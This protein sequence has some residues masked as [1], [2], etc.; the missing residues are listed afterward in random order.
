MQRANM[1]QQGETEQQILKRCLKVRKFL[2]HNKNKIR[3]FYDFFLF[4]EN[5]IE[6]VDNTRNT[7]DSNNE[8]EKRENIFLNMYYNNKHVNYMKIN[9]VC[10]IS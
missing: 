3:E 4:T 2:L 6:K 1:A 8:D 9:Y 7:S 5:F 10:S